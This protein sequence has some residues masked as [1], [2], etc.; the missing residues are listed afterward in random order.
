MPSQQEGEG[1]PVAVPV[2]N[3]IP[4]LGKRERGSEKDR[5]RLNA[6]SERGRERDDILR[7]R[8]RGRRREG[9]R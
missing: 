3:I 6:L 5:G 2:R 7:E 1:I 8:E 4:R 9:E